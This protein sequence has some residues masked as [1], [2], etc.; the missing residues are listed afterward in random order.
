[1]TPES[2]PRIDFRVKIRIGARLQ[3]SVGYATP[4]TAKGSGAVYVSRVRRDTSIENGLE[5][6]TVADNIR[7]G[8]ALNAVQIAEHLLMLRGSE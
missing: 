7:K 8:A 4:L 3:P 5:L 6:W 1:M 2:G